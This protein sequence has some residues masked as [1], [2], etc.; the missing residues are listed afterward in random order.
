MF[1]TNYPGFLLHSEPRLARPRGKRG[2][3]FGYLAV[4]FR[5]EK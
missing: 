5:L 4:I 3:T 2:P 1:S